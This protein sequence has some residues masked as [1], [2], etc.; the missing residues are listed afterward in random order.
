MHN[1]ENKLNDFEDYFLNQYLEANNLANKSIHYSKLTTHTQGRKFY[2][3]IKETIDRV[4]KKL[5][6]IEKVRKFIIID[7]EFTIENEM[8]T[9]TLT[10]RRLVVKEKYDNE[11]EKLY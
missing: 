1:D 4:N 11:L 7:H 8:M 3:R 5:S 2:N 6:V 9:P 10:V